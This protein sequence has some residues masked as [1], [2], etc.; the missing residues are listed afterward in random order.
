MVSY[1]L[2]RP[3]TERILMTSGHIPASGEPGTDEFLAA[4]EEAIREVPWLQKGPSEDVSCD[5][6]R[7]GY[8]EQELSPTR[9]AEQPEALKRDER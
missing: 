8:L 2:L 4:L 5:L 1:F 6:T 7:G 3:A 9:V